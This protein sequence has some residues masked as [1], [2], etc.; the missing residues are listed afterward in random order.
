MSSN[1]YFLQEYE[2]FESFP[3]VIC[4]V[5][6]VPEDLDKKG[7]EEKLPD[8]FV[9]GVDL[10]EGASFTSVAIVNKKGNMAKK[11]EL[12]APVLELYEAMKAGV[13]C[14]QLYPF[15]AKKSFCWRSDTLRKCTKQAAALLEAGLIEKYDENMRGYRL[16]VKGSGGEANVENLHRE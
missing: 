3:R 11:K 15:K 5:E 6:F 2:I 13:T 12:T 4:K 16:R 9:V 1:D 14:Q 8:G 7:K 10:S